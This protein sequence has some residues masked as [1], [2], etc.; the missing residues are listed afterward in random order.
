M[1]GTF[2]RQSP[3]PRSAAAHR[4]VGL[5]PAKCH[6]ACAGSGP[7]ASPQGQPQLSSV[8]LECLIPS[9]H[10]VQCCQRS[11]PLRTRILLWDSSCHK[12]IQEAFQP[13][14]CTPWVTPHT[15]QPPPAASRA[16]TPA[17]ARHSSIFCGSKNKLLH[18]LPPAT[19][20]D[21]HSLCP[22]PTLCVRSPPSP[23]RGLMGLL[24][25]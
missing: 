18:F 8:A 4:A 19:V 12:P 22:A 17:A 9:L 2:M 15:G 25:Y 7:D 3:K 11:L 1:K 21:D 6:K 10:P 20:C 14:R 13:W 5:C 16:G 24:L 23:S